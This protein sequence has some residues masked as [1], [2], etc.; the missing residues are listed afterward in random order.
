MTRIREDL[1]EILREEVTTAATYLAIPPEQAR[2][3]A[4]QV[5][6]RLRMRVAG[7]DLYLG[8][9]DRTQRAARIREEFS[10]NNHAELAR[11]YGLTVRRI[12]QI[13]A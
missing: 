1:A 6:D 12:R 5:E 3:L 7:T 8:R 11:R 9:L 4:L 2:A 10:G 13:V